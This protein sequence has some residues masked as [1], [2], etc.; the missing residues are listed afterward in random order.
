M[1]GRDRGLVFQVFT[2]INS[3]FQFRLQAKDAFAPRLNLLAQSSLQQAIG[4]EEALFRAG[5]NEFD[6]R[7]RL[8]EVKTSIQE[9]P[10]GKL[11]RFRQ[12]G[13]RQQHQLENPVQY[14]VPAV[15]VHLDHILAGVG[16]RRCHI[17][18]EHFIDG[19]IRGRITNPPVMEPVGFEREGGEAWLE[20]VPCN[21][22]RPWSADLDKADA[23]LT[24]GGCNC[25]D[26]V[27]R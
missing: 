23:A 18:Q 21:C 10:A 19:L 14:R 1:A 5:V 7:F 13:A 24:N 11:S 9:R 8:G 17:T 20:E 26:C 16:V 25:T 4:D 22:R 3:G 6:N 12:T 15:A 27:F 2:E